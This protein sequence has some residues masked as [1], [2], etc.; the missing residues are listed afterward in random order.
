MQRIGAAA[1]QQTGQEA[2]QIRQGEGIGLAQEEG[3]GLICVTPARKVDPGCTKGGGEVQ[4]VKC[5][6]TD[7]T[8]RIFLQLKMN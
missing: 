3:V 8:I 2:M 5:T 1:Q 4:M 6:I 7:K